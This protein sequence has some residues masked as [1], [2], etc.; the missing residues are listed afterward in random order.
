MAKDK[1]EKPAPP[2]AEAAPAKKGLPIKTIGIVGVIMALEGA[3]I[4]AFFT[5]IGPK[6]T[7]AEVE[8]VEIKSDDGQQIQ[9][10]QIV[11]DKFQNLQQGKVWFWDTAVFVQVKKKNAEQ[12]E[13]LLEQRN[14]EVKEG[15]SQ[16]ISRAQPAQLREPDRQTLNRQ[17]SGFLNKLFGNDAEGKPL[18]ERVLIPRCRGIP[19]EF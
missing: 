4:F 3:A 6:K 1:A 10:V 13:K 18:V 16:I 17:F 5:M 12:I 11:D 15:I 8:H 19:G 7:H 14:A 9:E 2:P